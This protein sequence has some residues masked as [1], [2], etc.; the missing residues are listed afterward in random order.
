[1]SKDYKNAQYLHRKL[2]RSFKAKTSSLRD[3]MLLNNPA[4][5]YS[6]IRNSRRTKATNINKLHV[7]ERTYVGNDVPDGFFD[8]VS[9]LKTSDKTRLDKSSFYQ[10]ATSNY[11]HIIKLSQESQPLKA[12]TETPRAEAA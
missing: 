12:I 5:T 3:S 6:M 10:E 2:V 9:K 8:S 7:G 4:K 1:M 11:N